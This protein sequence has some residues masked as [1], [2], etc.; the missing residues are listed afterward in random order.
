MYACRDC[1]AMYVCMQ[2]LCSYVCMHAAV[3]VV[4][5]RP[6]PYTKLNQTLKGCCVGTQ[7]GLGTKYSGV[8]G[9]ERRGDLTNF[10]PIRLKFWMVTGD[11]PT[12]VLS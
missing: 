6:N 7:D 3:F 11:N 12:E 10:R 8:G 4:G 2:R 1:V 9:S 5:A